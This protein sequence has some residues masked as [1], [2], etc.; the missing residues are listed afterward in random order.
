MHAFIQL[1]KGQTLHPVDGWRPAWLARMQSHLARIVVCPVGPDA[2]VADALE[3]DADGDRNIVGV[4]YPVRESGRIEHTEPGRNVVAPLPVRQF[5]VP[6]RR[7]EFSSPVFLFF[8]GGQDVRVV[9]I[10]E[11]HRL[12]SL[13]LRQ[14]ICLA[15]EMIRR[16]AVGRRNENR[17]DWIMVLAPQIDA[18]QLR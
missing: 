12:L 17:Q 15:V 18:R 11:K 16:D 6:A 10:V 14:E 13:H 5:L 4:F 2:V 1:A 3:I 9:R 7:Q 8:L